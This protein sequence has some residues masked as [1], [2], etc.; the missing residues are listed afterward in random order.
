VSCNLGTLAASDGN[1]TGS[2]PDVAVITVNAIAPN[3]CPTLFNTASVAWAGSQSPA[4]SNQVVTQITGCNP[5]LTLLLKTDSPDHV[6]E[7][8]NITYTITVG[9]NGNASTSGT[10]TVTDTRPAG[11][12]YVSASGT[13]WNCGEAA[14]VVTCTSSQVVAAG[15]SFPAITIVVTTPN[16]VCTPLTN[17]ASVSGGGD[18][19]NDPDASASAETTVIGCGSNLTLSKS[20]SPDPVVEGDNITYTVIVGNNGNASTEGTVTVTDTLPAGATYVQRRLCSAHE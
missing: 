6:V 1:T 15:A 12:T 19:G 18:A 3:T 11:V 4:I 9:N 16:D 10:V 14:G 20:D 17:N 7:G 13:G 5:G 8:N 2:E